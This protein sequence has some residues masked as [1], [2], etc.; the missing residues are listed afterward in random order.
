[1]YL[2]HVSTFT[3]NSLNWFCKLAPS[4]RIRY[5]CEN[6]MITHAALVLT[7]TFVP[8]FASIQLVCGAYCCLSHRSGVH[9]LGLCDVQIQYRVR[10][11]SDDG[12]LILST[13]CF[14]T[15]GRMDW[16]AILI[17]SNN[18]GMSRRCSFRHWPLG[19]YGVWSPT[20]YLWFRMFHISLLCRVIRFSG[21]TSRHFSSYVGELLLCVTRFPVPV[22]PNGNCSY[23]IHVWRLSLSLSH[24][25]RCCP[26]CLSLH[27][28]HSSMIHFS[29]HL[30]HD[31]KMASLQLEILLSLAQ[32]PR[33]CWIS[34]TDKEAYQSK[35]THGRFYNLS[36]NHCAVLR[37]NSM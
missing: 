18:T 10:S 14:S 37:T 9:I 33:S 19:I 1:M 36:Q 15:V 34:R 26:F 7:D 22:H 12:E 31:Y 32:Y 2:E 35:D 17:V 8:E 20:V 3:F 25:Q 16:T 27:P 28:A 6:S 29:V 24:F 5:F 30:Q 23:D 13:S 21:N 4:A 11:A